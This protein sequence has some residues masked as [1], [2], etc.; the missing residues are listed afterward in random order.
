MVVV[1]KRIDCCLGPRHCAVATHAVFDT[2]TWSTI[3][4]MSSQSSTYLENVAVNSD[5]GAGRCG[6][7]NVSGADWG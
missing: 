2:T 1:V 6:P 4:S 3:G 5:R 7:V